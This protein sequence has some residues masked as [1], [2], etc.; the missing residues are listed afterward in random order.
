MMTQTTPRFA[1]GLIIGKFYPLHAGHSRLIRTALAQCDRVTVQLIASSVESIPLEVRATWLREEHPTATIATATDDGEVDFESPAAWEHHMEVTRALLDGP[2][3]AVFTSDLYGEELAR[4]LGARWVPVDPHRLETPISGT[5]VRRDPGS[6]WWALSPAVRQ[7]LGRRIVVLGA[8]ST[9]ST[10]LAEALGAHFSVPCVPEYGREWSEIRP[11]GLDAPWHTAEFDL[12]VREQIAAE[13]TALRTS[14]A[15]FVICD[16]DVLATA[17]WHE[18]YLEQPAERIREQAAAHRP[19]LYL[20]TGDEIPFVQDGM[21]DG[22][23][24]RHAMQRRFREVLSAQ[25]VPWIELHG[26]PDERLREAADAVRAHLVFAWDF[27]LPL[28]QQRLHQQELRQQ[29]LCE[30]ELC[31][32]E[33]RDHANHQTEGA[34]A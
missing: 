12:I 27:A 33:L 8:E 26:T 20:L 19:L 10:T 21:R 16:T 25:D 32:Q 2:V 34:H 5:A 4:R 17:L 7:Y 29:E 28:E 1:H 24:I 3:D 30:Q 6:S 23:H 13:N 31:D 18:R 22:E 9:G 14:P 11:G 15:P